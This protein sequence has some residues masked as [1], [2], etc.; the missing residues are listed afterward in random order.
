MV[1]DTRTGLVDKK[2]TSRIIPAWNKP[3]IW[4]GLI[5]IG[6]FFVF[7]AIGV[8]RSYSIQS[9]TPHWI[10][11]GGI[12][13]LLPCLNRFGWLTGDK[14]SQKWSSRTSSLVSFCI[15][16]ISVVG[17]LQ[18]RNYELGKKFYE[19]KNYK[20]AITMYQKEID[21]WYLRLT[22]NY[23]EDMS[24]FGIAQSYCQLGDFEQARKTYQRLVEMS[25]GYYKGR[26]QDELAE[27]DRE[28][29]KIAAYEEQLDN[30][31]DDQQKAQV[32]FDLA[33]AYRKIECGQKAREQ[34]ALIQDLDIRESRK[35]QAKEFAAD[36]RW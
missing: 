12:I 32:L 8:I 26:G 11:L 33:L 18:G 5:C 31:T 28:L 7:A 30:T 20:A 6:Q 23:R 25:R 13:L 35:E 27:L 29:K 2:T 34:Y 19:Q 4:A 21:T 1:N 10:L 24:L 14:K 17:I 9:W 3:F 22:Y 16:L 36:D 15:I